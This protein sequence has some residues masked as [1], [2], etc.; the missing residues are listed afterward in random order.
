MMEYSIIA[1]A[2][3]MIGTVSQL[4]KAESHGRNAEL[5]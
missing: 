3:I 4:P 5:V 1:M 2:A